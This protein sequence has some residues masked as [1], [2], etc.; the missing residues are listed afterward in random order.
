MKP[1]ISL[2]MIVKN[3]EKVIERCLSSVVKFIDEIVIVDTGSIDNTKEIASK[4]TSKI[5]DF[6]WIDDFSAARNF[7]A[8]KASGEWILVLD[9]DEYVDE[10]NFKEFIRTIKEDN[11]DH[12]A[13]YAKI[14]NFSGTYGESLVQN[15]HDRIYKN[16]GN[17]YY[18]RRIHEQFISKDNSTLNIG[19]SNL[20]IFH[21]GYLNQTV[22]EKHKST[23]N[24]ELLD[25]EMSNNKNNGFD[26]FNLG[27]E[28]FSI[29]EYSKALDAYL[30]AFKLKKDYQLSWVPITVMQIINLL[31][32]LKK[33][34][35]ALNVLNEAEN[36][37]FSSPEFKYY[38]GEL[39]LKRG[40]IEDAKN[41]FFDLINNADEYNQVIFRP[42]L[43]DQKPHLRLAEIFFNK[44]DY[45]NAI[46]HYT[47][48]LNI[49]KNDKESIKK[50]IFI[51]SKFHNNSEIIAFLKSNDLINRN[52]VSSY[53][54]ASFDNGNPNLAINILD[55]YFEEHKLLYEICLLKKMCIN[56]EGEIKHLNNILDLEH[57]KTLIETNW[58]N[59]IDLYLLRRFLNE[60]ENN[61][62]LKIYESLEQNEQ[63]TKLMNLLKGKE[64]VVNV[65]ENLILYALEIF[66]KYKKYDLCNILLED[67]EQ[68]DK[69]TIQKVAGLLYANEFK[70]EALQ[71]Y[72]FCDWNTFT[73]QD[74]INIIESLLETNNIDSAIE[75]AKYAII[76]FRDYFQFYKI[77]LE[78]TSDSVT[79][80]YYFQKAIEIFSQSGYLEHLLA[81]DEQSKGL[82]TNERKI[83]D[84]QNKILET[85]LNS[86]D[87]YLTNNLL[88]KK[89]EFTVCYPYISFL[90]EDNNLAEVEF[91]LIDGNKRWGTIEVV[92]EKENWKLQNFKI[93]SDSNLD[94]KKTLSRANFIKRKPKILLSYR[95]FSGCNTLA[96]YKSIP[97]YITDDFEVDIVKCDTKVFAQKVLD[98]DI[99]VTTNMEFYQEVN[100]KNNKK[101][102]I[103][104]WH[105][106]PLKNMFYTDPHY[107]NKNSIATYWRQI[108]YLISYSD[109]Y[110]QIINKSIKTDPDNFVIT[111]SPRNDF[112]FNQHISRNILLKLLG[113]VDHGQKFIFYMPTFRNN[114]LLNKNSSSNLFGFKDFNLDKLENFLE[115]NNFELIVKLH[116]IYKKKFNDILFNC[117]RIN[118]YPENEANKEF[119][120]VYEVLSATD[121]LITDYSSVY[122][123]YLL[124]DKP[125]IFSIA[126]LN[127]YQ[128][129]RGFCLEPFNDWTPGPKIYTQE[130]LQNEIIFYDKEK[131]CLKRRNVKNK[132][133]QYFDG[134]S[135]E[136]VWNFISSIYQ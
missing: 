83:P 3:E 1:L 34:N 15:Y 104:T 64:K 26:Y 98:S 74:F 46:Y 12:D 77:I 17:I 131:Y 109:L 117:S 13:Y 136:R 22:K 25:K 118:M 112:L 126:D 90:S 24:K 95:D 6:K 86:I 20:L 123:D 5:Y 57:L 105:G 135:S 134:N 130:Q 65:E 100:T 88:L 122:F 103:D 108:D 67:I 78:N 55:G 40:Q 70:I 85:F 35:N 63:I 11:G 45:N 30:N 54:L 92:K 27:N 23:R 89:D 53:V 115:E 99:I 111:G 32:M 119:V 132:V 75:V 9:A 68:T 96:L 81:N 7:A 84:E 82:Q 102:V 4:Y 59:I 8:S 33:Y 37:Y 93:K 76:I 107:F 62:L 110:S 10:D 42:D 124:L 41:V 80:K 71:L 69:S 28:Y 113:K 114:D 97:H 129:E 66:M 14:I 49:N 2:C 73:E 38:K 48:V 18:H 101:I 79:F 61:N 52:N 58:I 87:L 39:F 128:K 121:I 94:K 16:N 51:L 106:F 56:A 50:V 60:N 120:D 36:I 44:K 72:E 125:I 31:I 21:S 91:L 29:G 47:S 116:P 19:I 133:H 43:K 127:E